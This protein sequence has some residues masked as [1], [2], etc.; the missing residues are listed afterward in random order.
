MI[1]FSAFKKEEWFALYGAY[2]W[3][4]I[5]SD[6]CRNVLFG[7]GRDNSEYEAMIAFGL[8]GLLMW[9]ISERYSGGWSAYWFAFATASFAP[10][11]DS[12]DAA[13]GGLLGLR[14]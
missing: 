4:S 9:W 10:F 6:Y 5:V 3:A 11:A 2:I 14:E 1:A 8:W 12:I 13:F 7:L